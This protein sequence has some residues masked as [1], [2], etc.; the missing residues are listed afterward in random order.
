MEKGLKNLEEKEIDT[1]TSG[2]K[3]IALHSKQGNCPDEQRTNLRSYR[4]HG[5]QRTLA[6]C[7]N[8][9]GTEINPNLSEVQGHN[10]QSIGH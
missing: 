5:E 1:I 4:L 6:R 10:G 8:E 9:A 2:S 7:Y 3:G